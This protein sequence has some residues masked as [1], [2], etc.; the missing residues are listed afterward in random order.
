MSMLA[1]YK[2]KGGIKELV[3][4]V[5]DSAEPKRTQLLEMVRKEDKEFAA[6]VEAMILKYDNIR[7][8]PENMVAEIIAA[9]APKFVAVAIHGETPEFIKLVEKCIGKAFNDYKAER[10]I[11]AET[12][13]TANQV[14]SARRKLI[15]EARKLESEGKIKFANLSGGGTSTESGIHPTN[16]ELAL[17]TSPAPDLAGTNLSP[18]KATEPCPPIN[19]FHLEPPLPGLSGERF[20][21][22]L[23]SQ[24]GK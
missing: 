13:P 24:L 4:L 16:P 20:E 10:D 9:T 6:Q 21:T 18:T 8:L 2:K 3:K 23:K 17:P 14:E 19:S 11:L 22:F 15:V 7:A 5:E 1:R 12:P